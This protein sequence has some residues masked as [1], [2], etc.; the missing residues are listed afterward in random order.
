[1]NFLAH[2]FLSGEDEDI[3]VG[4]MIADF[5]RNKEVAG[6]SPEVQKGIHLH[7]LIDSYTD[8][9]EEVRKGTSRLRPHHRKYAPVVIDL[10]YDYLLAK[11]WDT[12]SNIS[13]N[14]F[15]Q[16]MYQVLNKR[17]EEMP[18]KLKERLPGMIESNWLVKYGTFDG[19]HY[20]LEMMDRRT[21]FP[22]N[23]TSGIGDL[24]VGMEDFNREFNTFF[25]DVFTYV[26]NRLDE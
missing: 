24:K 14:D 15:C 21:K 10:F 5:I 20:V 7:R 26:E 19:L 18:L 22:S 25:P 3:I 17:M 4:N 6:F 9:H 13:L 16:N 23:F 8:N 1:M 11:N 2:L 12:Y